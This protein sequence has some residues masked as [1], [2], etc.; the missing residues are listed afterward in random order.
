[1]IEE[2]GRA[3]AVT[4]LVIALAIVIL[5]S[6]FSP[7]NGA[8]M[9][10]IFVSPTAIPGVGIDIP[11]AGDLLKSVSD[12]RPG[13][14]DVAH[15]DTALSRVVITSATPDGDIVLVKGSYTNKRSSSLSIDTNTITFTSDGELLT[16]NGGGEVE[17]ASGTTAGMEWSIRTNASSI[18]MTIPTS[19][20]RVVVDIAVAR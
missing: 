11:R 4:G 6:V 19:D 8:G 1:M 7:V 9:Q 12:M 5:L 15:M 10:K 3:Y 18:Q 17:L 14:G 2:G 20:E 16:T 13:G